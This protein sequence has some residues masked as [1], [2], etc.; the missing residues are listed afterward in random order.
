VIREEGTTSR[1]AGSMSYESGSPE[2][3][4]VSSPTK[5]LTKTGQK[6][7]N[8]GNSPSYLKKQFK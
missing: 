6:V 1:T 3:S 8:I 5:I 4:P 2:I 7:S